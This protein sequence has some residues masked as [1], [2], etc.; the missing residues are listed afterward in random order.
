MITE[1]T[2]QRRWAVLIGIDSYHESLGDLKYAGSDCRRLKEILQSES[3]GFAEE[4]TLLLNDSEGDERRPTFANIHTWLASWLAQPDE[5][6]LVLFYFAGH[7]RELDGKSYLVPG[8]A[9]LATLHTLGIP[10]AN[11]QELIGRCKAKQKVLILDACHSGAGLDVAVM[12]QAMESEISNAEGIYTIASCGVDELSHEWNEKKQGVFSYYLAEALSGSCLPDPC[13]RLTIDAVYDWTFER[14]RGWAAKHRCQ[15]TPRRVTDTAGSIT[16][17][18]T[19]TPVPQAPSTP[20]NTNTVKTAELQDTV[21]QLRCQR[22]VRCPSY[23]EFLEE[24]ECKGFLAECAEH[25]PKCFRSERWWVDYGIGLSLLLG[26]LVILTICSGILFETWPYLV[27]VAGLIVAVFVAGWGWTH[28]VFRNYWHLHCARLCSEDHDTTGFC[29]HAEAI[30]RQGISREEV[31][32]VLLAFS[33]G[34]VKAGDAA[35][36]KRVLE[37]AALRW[38]S[39][40]AEQRLCDLNA[41]HCQRVTK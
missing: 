19:I 25:M 29:E 14:V 3:L 37:L 41:R 28:R 6:D 27:A 1:N 7:G 17:R 4:R 16:L 33:E 8:D 13:G 26:S 39:P 22:Y 30:K 32:D 35:M 15:Q 5:D 9:T 20:I 34:Q 11:I 24:A 23:Q 18:N 31:V 40:H 2:T 12:S 36:G 38:K 10:L 21:E